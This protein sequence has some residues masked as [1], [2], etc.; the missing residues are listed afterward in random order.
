MTET[1][2]F[3][4]HDPVVVTFEGRTV[5]AAVVAKGKDGTALALA[6]EAILGGYVGWMPVLWDP[7]TGYTDLLGG[8]LVAITRLADFDD[9]QD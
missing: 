1:A 7:A 3:D 4:E 6:F 8:R 2:A 9:S 5:T